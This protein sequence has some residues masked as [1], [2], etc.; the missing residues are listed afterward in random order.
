MAQAAAPNI[1]GL[2]R[3]REHGFESETVVI[4][5]AHSPPLLFISFP[6]QK[7]SLSYLIK[8]KTPKNKSLKIK[9]LMYE[10][11]LSRWDRAERSAVKM[12]SSVDLSGR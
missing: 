6:V 1:H 9:N 10:L 8:G 5:G 7:P 12:A 3:P 4:S 11:N 2:E